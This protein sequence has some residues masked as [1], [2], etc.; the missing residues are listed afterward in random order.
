MADTQ[1]PGG[2]IGA[3]GLRLATGGTVE[4]EFH[5]NLIGRQA[6]T[7]FRE[8][9]DNDPIVGGILYSFNMLCRQVDWIIE[10]GDASEEDVEYLEGCLEDMSH[11]WADFISEVLSMLPYGWSYHEIVYKRRNGRQ[12]ETSGKSS[13]KYDDNKIGWAKLPIRAQDTLQE[14]KFNPDTGAVEGFVQL[15]PPLY[16]IVT[17]PLAKA[18]LFRTTS[19]KNNPEGRSLLRNAYRP[20]YFKNRIETI[21][22]TGIERDLAGF[23]V[24]GIPAAYLSDTATPDKK[25]LVESFRQV[26]ANIR[27]DKQEYVIWPKAYDEAGNELFTLELMSAGGTRAFDTSAIIQ[28][29]DQRIAMTVLADFILLGHEKVGSF[30]LSSDKTDLFA[31]ALGTI[32]DTIEETINRFAIPRLWEM[33]GWDPAKAPILRHGDIEDRDLTALGTFL[34]SLTSM[35]MTLFP[36]EDLDKY[37]RKT[38]H[39]PEKSEET[40]KLQE[41]AKEEAMMQQQQSMG[42]PGQEGQDD[43]E[44]DGQGA[45]TFADK[46]KPAPVAGGGKPKPPGGPGGAT[47]TPTQ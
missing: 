32:L 17:I 2:E 46:A 43:F 28:R 21:E 16:K 40:I 4:E 25:A 22:G 14:W 26:G 8:M 31:V 20:W 33:N 30:A 9:S 27:R 41:E 29:Y 10:Q 18:L 19:F 1:N 47:A 35:G 39:L 5:P 6:L 7:T 44:E 11:S 37:L 38:A 23:P 15:A 24:L 42:A 13:S 45:I 36:D 12:K 34:S 3:T